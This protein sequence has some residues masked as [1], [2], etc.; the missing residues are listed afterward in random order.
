MSNIFIVC[1]MSRGSR[2]IVTDPWWS[3]DSSLGNSA[4][5]YSASQPSVCR[6]P[7]VVTGFSTGQQETK[8][9]F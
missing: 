1:H 4:L 5:E 3:V 2:A 8:F 6:P 9:K 7:G